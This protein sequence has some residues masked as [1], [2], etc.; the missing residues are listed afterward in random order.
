MGTRIAALGLL[1][2]FPA[3][4]G[5]NPGIA[6][7]GYDTTV[8]EKG[9]CFEKEGVKHCF[10]SVFHPSGQYGHVNV[11]QPENGDAQIKTQD[12]RTI[13]CKWM[14]SLYECWELPK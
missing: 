6:Y 10:P 12:G 11:P 14:D 13:N 7:N 3:Y 2:S 5:E 1:F 4:A 8:Y 9:V